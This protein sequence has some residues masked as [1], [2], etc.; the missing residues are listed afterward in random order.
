MALDG[1]PPIGNKSGTLGRHQ[2]GARL[3]RESREVIP[4]R[5]TGNEQ[6]IEMCFLERGSQGATPMMENCGHK[7]N[8]ETMVSSFGR[9]VKRMA[10]NLPR[11]NPRSQEEQKF[12]GCR[13]DAGALKKVSD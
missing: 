6:A 13:A 4:I 5:W 3:S 10:L 9:S 12:L 11:D 8:E 2:E 1:K 7:G